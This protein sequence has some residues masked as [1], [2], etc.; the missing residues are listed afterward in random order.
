[1]RTM[2]S[3]VY[4][5]I[6]TQSEKLTYVVEKCGRKSSYTLAWRYKNKNGY[7]T[8]LFINT[9][10]NDCF[11]QV[12]LTIVTSWLI[13]AI[14]TATNVLPPTPGSWG[15]EARTDTRINSLKDALWFRIPHPGEQNGY[16]NKCS[17]LVDKDLDD[18]IMLARCQ[19]NDS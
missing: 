4:N 18:R 8:Y 5:V 1:M 17:S 6:T 16:R 3:P 13:C 12:M 10:S 7:S 14:L 2:H 9:Y 11:R 15:Y 19:N